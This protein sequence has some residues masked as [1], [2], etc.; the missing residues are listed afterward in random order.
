MQITRFVITA[1]DDEGQKLYLC[2]DFMWAESDNNNAILTFD[3]EFDALSFKYEHQDGF[4]HT[5]TVSKI[6]W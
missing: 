4:Y 5:L 3:T 2:D 6:E 1:R